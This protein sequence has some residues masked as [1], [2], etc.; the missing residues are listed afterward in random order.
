MVEKVLRNTR[1]FSNITRIAIL[2]VQGK[3]ADNNNG[4]GDV[5]SMQGLP[6][7]AGVARRFVERDCDPLINT[8]QGR[9]V[10]HQKDPGQK[11][12]RRCY[13]KRGEAAFLCDELE[14]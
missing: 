5:S 3:A 10:L 2:I 1:R 9:L 11:P 8:L 7:Q 12:A 13:L 14:T 6:R 4:T